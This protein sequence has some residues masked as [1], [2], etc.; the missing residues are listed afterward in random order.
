MKR[1]AVRV[2]RSPKLDSQRRALEGP[3]AMP[4][5]VTLLKRR[6]TLLV[7]VDRRLCFLLGLSKRSLDRLLARKHTLDGAVVGVGELRSR[8]G[9]RQLEAVPR[10]VH[11]DLDRVVVRR[12]A[13]RVVDVLV[14][15]LVGDSVRRVE[16]R[17][18]LAREL[19][20][21]VA[22]LAGELP[23]A[24]RRDGLH[25]RA[26]IREVRRALRDDPAVAAEERDRAALLVREVL[27]LDR[28]RR[29]VVREDVVDERLHRQHPELI[30][31][32]WIALTEEVERVAVGDELVPAALGVDHGG[33]EG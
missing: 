9:R 18:R 3:G 17:E 31:R 28:L 6:R 14:E 13:G 26:R 8:R 2:S 23:R 29:R 25:V 1:Y 7:R 16:A 32:E 12:V 20:R 11:E 15:L 21:V 4:L 30:L 5:T 22:L 33:R 27:R 19:A 24:D 10:C